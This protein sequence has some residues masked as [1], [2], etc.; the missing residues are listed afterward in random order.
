ML[1]RAARGVVRSSFKRRTFSTVDK[2]ESSLTP[3]NV[4]AYAAFVTTLFGVTGGYYVSTDEDYLFR[5]YDA[6]PWFVN[7]VAA[8]ILGLPT[9]EDGRL[10]VRVVSFLA[11]FFFFFTH[12]ISPT[13]PGIPI[14][15]ANDGERCR[16]H[17][18]VR[19]RS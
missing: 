18:L 8:P 2:S 5:L 15:A 3:G 1:S 4:A 12:S 7:T 17:R 10:D 11:F 9:S 19:R 13:S 6:S 14:R 16:R